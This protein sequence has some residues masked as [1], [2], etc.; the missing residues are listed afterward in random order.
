MVTRGALSAAATLLLTGCASAT[1]GETGT[2][3]A[4]LN[5]SERVNVL[6]FDPTRFFR[7][8]DGHD[9]SMIRIAYTGD[10]YAWPVYSIA[11]MA[12][13]LPGEA[14]SPACGD[15]LTARMVRAPAPPD[16]DRPRQRGSALVAGLVERGEVSRSGLRNGLT[17]AGVEWLEA[18]GRS[19]PDFV[20]KLGASADLQWTPREVSHPDSSGE[21]RIVVHADI[22]S[23]T[24]DKFAR[25][26]TYEGYIAEGS[27]AAWAVELA[28]VLETCWKPAPAPAPWLA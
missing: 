18:D 3:E 4:M 14:R 6:A 19:C 20:D 8:E 22:V 10:D 17:S 7:E 25:R 9:R 11:V 23:V 5:V 15:R 24:F 16:L 27:P 28:A 12:G 2:F 21:I 1:F 26:S 13:C